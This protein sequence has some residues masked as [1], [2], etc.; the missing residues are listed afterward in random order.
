MVTSQ[1]SS[2]VIS[3]SAAKSFYVTNA[4]IYPFQDL[5]EHF[6]RQDYYQRFAWFPEAV[7]FFPIGES[8][9]FWI[10]VFLGDNF[11]LDYEAD[12]A[13]LLP[14]TNTTNNAVEIGGGDDG[15]IIFINLSQGV[16]KLIYQERYLTQTEI[17]QI[18]DELP[19]EDPQE[20]FWH[21]FGPKVCQLTFISTSSTPKPEILIPP[22]G[23]DLKML[24]LHH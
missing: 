9:I 19:S 5:L 21:S 15:E 12:Y 8:A 2:F 14:F 3:A 24:F 17:D 20:A 1:L 6:E 16:Y 23:R 13:V 11:T 10:E 18:P 7:T 22:R 4:G